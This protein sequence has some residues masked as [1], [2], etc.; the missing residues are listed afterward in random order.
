MKYSIKIRDSNKVNACDNKKRVML[1]K[2]FHIVSDLMENKVLQ[3][4]VWKQYVKFYGTNI[5]KITERIKFFES[6]I[7]LILN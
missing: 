4:T 1:K 5:G 6:K 7:L 3:C 2:C